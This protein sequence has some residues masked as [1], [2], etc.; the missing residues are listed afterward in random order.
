[1]EYVEWSNDQVVELRLVELPVLELADADC[2]SLALAFPRNHSFKANNAKWG[3][4][5]ETDC[6][7]C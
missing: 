2:T 5:W 4:P 3:S 1:M 6:I 7:V